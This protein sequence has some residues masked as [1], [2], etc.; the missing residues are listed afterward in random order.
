[1]K[2]D[3]YVFLLIALC[4]AIS[5]CARAQDFKWPRIKAMEL[6]VGASANGLMA[7]GGYVYFFQ[8]KQRKYKRFNTLVPVTP[9]PDAAYPCVYKTPLVIPPGL[10][11]KLS[12]FYEQG[13]GRDVTYR[14]IGVDAAFL[15]A[16][17]YTKV[18]YV[19]LK[20][21]A[22]ASNDALITPEEGS[23]EDYNQ[24]NPGVLG[25]IEGE[26][27]LGRMRATSIIAGWDQRYL[28]NN[29]AS[30]GKQRWYAYAGVRFKIRKKK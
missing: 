25:G 30:W 21:G 4:I 17:Y 12:A 24:I 7:Y 9:Y 5:C 26:R 6:G 29:E 14:I 16:I 23:S 15:Y 3:P 20:A 28:F 2:K 13:S 10:S 22:T 8:P 27:L 19:S 11:F 1:M 18:L